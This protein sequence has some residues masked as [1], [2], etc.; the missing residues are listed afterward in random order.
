MHM[1]NKTTIQFKNTAGTD[2]RPAHDDYDGSSGNNSGHRTQNQS[3]QLVLL[4]PTVV[5]LMCS[6]MLSTI[7]S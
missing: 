6:L 2:E 5:L 7:A 4:L 1:C 3:P